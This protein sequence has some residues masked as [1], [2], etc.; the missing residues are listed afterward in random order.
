MQGYLGNLLYV[1]LFSFSFL[2]L[3]APRRQFNVIVTSVID[4]DTILVNGKNKIRL[5][6]IDAPE[7]K[8]KSFDGVHIGLLSK[9]WL[10]KKILNKRVRLVLHGRGFYNRWLGD[11]YIA[12]ENINLKII[13][14]GFAL[15]YG[16]KYSFFSFMARKKKKGI[17]NTSGFYS[18][19]VYRKLTRRN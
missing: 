2:L 10:E 18:P 3:H 14:K 6:D 4:G 17:W 11:I 19:K 16:Q 5:L 9:N 1:S 8:Q 15:S 12:K 13:E 7:I